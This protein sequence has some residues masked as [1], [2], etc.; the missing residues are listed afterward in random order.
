VQTFVTSIRGS[1]KLAT[2]LVG[3]IVAGLLLLLLFPTASAPRAV[4]VRNDT[5]SSVGIRFESPKGDKLDYDLESGEAVE[6][7]YFRG[8][9]KSGGLVHV[10]LTARMSISG[11]VA[12][13]NFALPVDG[14]ARDISVSAD[15]FGEGQQGLSEGTQSLSVEVTSAHRVARL[16]S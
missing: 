2:V 6:F 12:T 7:V 9:G 14:P 4:V 5:H 13:R 1:F 8:K 3:I 15:W 10:T 11:D 16:A